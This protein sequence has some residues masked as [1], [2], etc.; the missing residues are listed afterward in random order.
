[1]LIRVAVCWILLSFTGYRAAFSQTS[2]LDC[3]QYLQLVKSTT[4]H[5]VLQYKYKVILRD[6]KSLRNKDSIRGTIYKYYNEYVDS[7]DVFLSMVAGGY[8]FKGN[9]RTKEAS[10]YRLAEVE[11]KLG[12]KREDMTQDIMIIPDSLLTTLGKCTVSEQ[13]GMLVVDYKLNMSHSGIQ[14]LVFYIRERDRSL[15]EIKLFMTDAGVDNCTTIY[16]LYDF[17]NDHR[18]NIHTESYF[19]TDRKKAFL[20]GIFKS[21]TLHTLL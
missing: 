6:N 16:S 7:N 21:Y 12:L 8:F 2:L 18:N 1:M 15:S 20:K 3:I 13:A 10:L 9:F 4:N 14:K 19:Q 5:P 17:R 11:R